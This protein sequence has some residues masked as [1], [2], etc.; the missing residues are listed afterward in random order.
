ML[1]NKTLIWT[2][3]AVV[4]VTALALVEVRL[5]GSP[6][7]V[8]QTPIF[9]VKRG[10]LTVDI[11]E[12]GTINAREQIIIKNEVE[13]KTSIIY[14]IPE[15]TQV[16]KG[17]YPNEFKKAEAEITLAEEELTR[18]KDILKWSQTL[19]KFF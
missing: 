5:T 2:A 7:T 18:A 6:T 10:P 17:E 19:Y 14:L 8:S 11:V 16:K 3:A 13:G 9:I 4:L 1:K 15:G 12:S